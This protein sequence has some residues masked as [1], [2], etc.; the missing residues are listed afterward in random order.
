MPRIG[1]IEIP[2][3]EKNEFNVYLVE[4]DDFTERLLNNTPPN[5][6]QRRNIT[7]THKFIITMTKNRSSG[8]ALTRHADRIVN[9]QTLPETMQIHL[10]E[11]LWFHSGTRWGWFEQ[12]RIIAFN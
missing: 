12:L 9:L 5:E 6:R 4:K 1:R 7:A 11:Y 2:P 3:T 8:D 10:F